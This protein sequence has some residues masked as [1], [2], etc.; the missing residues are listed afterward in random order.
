MIRPCRLVDAER[1]KKDTKSSHK[2]FEV[3]AAQGKALQGMYLRYKHLKT[4]VQFAKSQ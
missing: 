3:A 2:D 1:N 4:R